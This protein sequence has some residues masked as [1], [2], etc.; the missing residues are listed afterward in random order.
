M[1]FYSSKR[2][3]QRCKFFFTLNRWK[4]SH[5]GVTQGNVSFNLSRNSTPKL[6]RKN[7]S[8]NTVKLSQINLIPTSQN[9]KL[10][11]PTC[12]G[13]PGHWCRWSGHQTPRPLLVRWGFSPFQKDRGA[14]HHEGAGYLNNGH[15]L[16]EK[17][18]IIKER[19]EIKSR[20]WD[21]GKSEHHPSP[22]DRS[23]T[24]DLQLHAHGKFL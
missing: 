18:H 20:A 8:C 23:Q 24:D 16:Y 19:C 3:R 15:T 21:K 7:A 6:S 12:L 22:P 5:R 10:S 13:H 2:L 11:P 1:K 17:L 4:K 14:T 9:C